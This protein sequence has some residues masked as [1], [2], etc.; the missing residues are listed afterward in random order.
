MSNLS[1]RKAS[2]KEGLTFRKKKPFCFLKRSTVQSETRSSH[3]SCCSHPL[4]YS[5]FHVQILRSST[6]DP[7]QT[8]HRI[9]H[10]KAP[11][12]ASLPTNAPATSHALTPPQPA[13]SAFMCFSDLKKDEILQKHGMSR[14]HED[15][16]NLVADEWKKLSDKD[17]AYWDEQSRNDKVRY[18]REKA[19]W[20]GPSLVPKRRAKKNPL[21]PKRPMSAFL[22]FSQTRRTMVKKENP[23]MSNT[24]VSRLLGEM[25]R[26]ASPKETAPYREQ[27]LLERAI[28]NKDIKK[29]KA[30][31]ARLDADS[32]ISHPSLRNAYRLSPEPSPVDDYHHLRPLPSNISNAFDTLRMDSFEEAPSGN[33]SSRGMA[34]FRPQY[35]TSYSY[36]YPYSYHGHPGELP[37]RKACALL[38]PFHS[39][40][41]TSDSS[42]RIPPPSPS[43]YNG[44]FPR[45]SSAGDAD[46]ASFLR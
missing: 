23:D 41:H 27:E 46:S 28:Y 18:V 24:D 8:G 37:R 17:R 39:L 10:P 36:H 33:S 42:C 1:Y 43:Q 26:N 35:T 21:A 40:T 13:R 22:K 14:N 45:R 4:F 7:V 12:R 9:H 34:T 30:E 44:L 15:I 11:S 16:L 5:I 29:F 38:D 3:H 25:W 31:Q 32:R 19:A 2:E 6:N 20:N